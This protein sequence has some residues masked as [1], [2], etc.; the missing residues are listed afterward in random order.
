MLNMYDVCLAIT[1]A[2]QGSPLVPRIRERFRGPEERNSGVFSGAAYVFSDHETSVQRWTGE[3]DTTSFA[4]TANSWS[5]DGHRWT[6]SRGYTPF[7]VRRRS[8]TP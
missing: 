1:L 6:Q 4:R 2:L 8:S 3:T 7:L 5:S